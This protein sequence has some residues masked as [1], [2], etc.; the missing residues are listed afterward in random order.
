[1]NFYGQ[2]RDLEVAIMSNGKHMH[3]AEDNKSFYEQDFIFFGVGF[4]FFGRIASISSIS[5]D[6]LIGHNWTIH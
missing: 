1:V 6:I 4:N 5:I 3:V 2:C